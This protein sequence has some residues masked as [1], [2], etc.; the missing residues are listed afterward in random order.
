M[1]FF[2]TKHNYHDSNI[3]GY[4]WEGDDLVIK[5]NPCAQGTPSSVIF[6]NVKNKADIDEYF[7]KA[8]DFSSQG[9]WSIYSIE[10]TG[11][12]EYTVH[13]SS[14]IKILCDNFVEL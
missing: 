6:L 12:Q 13:V 2:K 10:K 3:I 11:K 8:I 9:N 14:P 4:K 1:N 7:S 5:I